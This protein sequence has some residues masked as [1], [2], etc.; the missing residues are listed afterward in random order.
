[1]TRLDTPSIAPLSER[2]RSGTARL[3]LIYGGFFL[4]WSVLL[5]ALIN[6]QIS[7]Y[8]EHIVDDILEQRV[9]YLSGVEREQLPAALA[10]TAATD[11]RGV[12]SFGVFDA[13]GRY[14]AGN[15]DRLP[16]E[17]PVDGAL[18]RLANGIVRID[19]VHTGASRGVAVRV[20][21]GSS[22]VLTRTTDAAD[23]VGAII[24]NGFI[25]ALS[26]TLIPGL[27]GG[28]LLARG[29]LK[30]VR[31]IET[32]VA[33]I[34]RGD[35]GV[36]LPISERRDEVDMLANIVN[37]MLDRLETLLGEVKGVSDSI[38]HDLRTPLTRLRAQLYRLQREIPPDDAHAATIERCITDTDNL[39]NRFRALLRISELEDLQ[40]RAGF[41]EVDLREKLAR[42]HELYSPLAE[43]K[44][45]AFALELPAILAGVRADGGL[46][47]EAI[48][49]L[50]DNALKFTPDGGRVVLRAVDEKIGPRIDV[51]DSGPGVPAAERDA[52]LHR[53]YRTKTCR[54][55]HECEAPGF[56]LGLSIVSAIVK[57]HDYRFEI[58]DAESGTGT[59]MTIYCSS[60]AG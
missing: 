35:L 22:I 48:S 7:S 33:P 9:A 32:A 38:A 4:A 49:N 26:L 37:R 23:R 56:G 15:I 1:M 51:I 53:F 16:P 41:G 27:L 30:R 54:K 45:I 44:R 58:A 10:M 17:L 20:A 31:D 43:D 34:M 50:V 36:R 12:M 29:S 57:L 5:V 60:N 8:L 59:R 47:F 52:V 25:W 55:E 3:I 39:L 14:V 11:R 18:H 6:W 24:R 46:L 19:G 2:W 21:D 42:V 13:A 40:R 28:F